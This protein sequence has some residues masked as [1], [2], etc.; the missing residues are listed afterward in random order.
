MAKKLKAVLAGYGNIGRAFENI[1]LKT[2]DDLL[3]LTICEL[4][5]GCNCLDYIAD[6]G[7]EIDVVIN[8]ATQPTEDILN[9]CIRKNIDYMD[10]GLEGYPMD[11]P[12]HDYFN[13]MLN[14][15]GD[16]R[17]MYGFG[18]NPGLLEHV[19]FKHKP[20][21]KHLA[22]EFEYD[23]ATSPLDKVFNTW[24]PTSYYDEAVPAGK[25]VAGGARGFFDVTKHFDENGP[26][27]LKAGGK[28]REFMMIPHEE[29]FS[30]RRLEQ[31][32]LGAGYL[33]QAPIAMQEF[34]RKYG[35]T[36]SE[37]EIAGI[38]TLHDVQGKD[39]TGMLFYDFSD[40]L[41][42]VGNIASHQEK[43]KTFGVN[44]TCW[45]TA[46]GV[47]AGLRLLPYV[48]AGKPV[49]MSDLSL[50]MPDEIDRVCNDLGFNLE[51]I[52]YAVDRREFEKEVLPLFQTIL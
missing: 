29:L 35:K 43:Y 20:R 4:K 11:V 2:G 28:T 49:T 10:A 32:C 19:Y 9:L 45:Q 24:S 23:E 3:D 13:Q 33:Y 38:P 39:H 42:F 1:L 44:A 12:M 18:V 17:M 22:F 47:H 34:C 51:R 37:E 5:N 6:H 26:L 36:A 46:C 27:K 40:N 21:G 30:M 48:K 14:L 15:R 25:V 7:E 16:I 50:A 31:N 52:D 41:Y 8:L